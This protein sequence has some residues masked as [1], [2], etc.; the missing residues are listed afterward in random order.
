MVLRSVRHTKTD[1]LLFGLTEEII[2]EFHTDIV[3]IKVT[4]LLNTTALLSL[5]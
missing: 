1:P 3:K 5:V 4:F 2:T